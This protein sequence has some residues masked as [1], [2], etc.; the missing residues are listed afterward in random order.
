M[1]VTHFEFTTV[2]VGD[3]DLEFGSFVVVVPVPVVVVAVV[4]KLSVLL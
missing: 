3:V 1:F 4:L 2:E